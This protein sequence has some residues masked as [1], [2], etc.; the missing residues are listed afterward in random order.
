M[1]LFS[2]YREILWSKDAYFNKTWSEYSLEYTKII[3]VLF[4]QRY[5]WRQHGIQVNNSC[6]NGFKV[7][8]DIQGHAGSV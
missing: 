4:T 3:K 5:R 7:V 6:I 8:S 1:L 2:N